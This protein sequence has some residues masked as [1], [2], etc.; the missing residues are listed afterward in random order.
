MLG[1]ICQI[2]Y[3]VP[4]AMAAAEQMRHQFGCGP[5]KLIEHIEVEWAEL[6]GK[7]FNFVHTSAFGQWGD[8]MLELIQLDSEPF[9]LFAQPGIHHAA[10]MVDDL[11]TAYQRFAEQGYPCVLKAMTG[12]GT[13]FAFLDARATLGHLIEIYEKSEQLTGFYAYIK[14]A[15]GPANLDEVFLP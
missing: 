3:H 12:T 10:I 2:A 5:F 13:E 11:Q 6:N 15:A 9:E 14:G 1:N 4:N 8:V 7:P